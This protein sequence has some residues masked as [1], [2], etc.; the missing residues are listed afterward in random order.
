MSKPKTIAERIGDIRT[1]IAALSDERRE[2][3]VQQRN[4]AELR[5]S[6]NRLLSHWRDKGEAAIVRELQRAACGF[7]PEVLTI[8]GNA[9][10][11][12]TPGNAPLALDL[13]PLL[14]ALFADVLRSR[15]GELLEQVPEG[16]E[17]ATRR[18]RTAEID[19][20]LDR[21]ESEEESFI[22]QSEA[23]GTPIGRRPDA[24]PEIVL[25]VNG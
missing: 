2:L 25:A 12:V 18:A 20:K 7:A 3:I 24:R 4:R 16:V 14:S 5:E 8:K 22:E 13:G 21:L 17:S 11:S 1:R 19:R 23:E 10:V 15:I 6:I 9:A